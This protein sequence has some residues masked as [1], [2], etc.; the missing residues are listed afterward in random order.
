MT[1][2]RALCSKNCRLPFVRVKVGGSQLVEPLE[3]EVG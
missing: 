2:C 1:L 3:Y